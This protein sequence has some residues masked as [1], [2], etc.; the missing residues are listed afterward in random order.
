[1]T[2]DEGGCCTALGRAVSGGELFRNSGCWRL[3]PRPVTHLAG[4]ARILWRH[5]PPHALGVIDVE[6]GDVA[7]EVGVAALHQNLITEWRVEA[8]CLGVELRRVVVAGVLVVLVGVL[9][10]VVAVAMAAEAA[11]ADGADRGQEWCLTNSPARPRG[12]RRQ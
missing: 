11:A 6:L 8:V 4:A 3:P 9:V 5:I 1:M 12:V 10:A 2:V 7:M